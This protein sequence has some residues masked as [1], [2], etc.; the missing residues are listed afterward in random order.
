M[1]EYDDPVERGVSPEISESEKERRKRKRLVG[2]HRFTHFQEQYLKAVAGSE[3]LMHVIRLL[4]REDSSPEGEPH[5][6]AVRKT[7][8]AI[9]T[10]SYEEKARL[11]KLLEDKG[12]EVGA[13]IHLPLAPMPTSLEGRAS[14]DFASSVAPAPVS[15][16]KPEEKYAYFLELEEQ[17]ES[18]DSDYNDRVSTALVDLSEEDLD[19]LSALL[20]E[21]KKV[22]CAIKFMG[23]LYRPQGE[24]DRVVLYGVFREHLVSFLDPRA[25]SSNLA[26]RMIEFGVMSS[27][28]EDFAPNVKQ[29]IARSTLLNL[30]EAYRNRKRIHE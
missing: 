7:D 30:E 2:N 25:D 29:G 21:K 27:K 22:D 9:N 12:D 5:L 3:R 20:L 4:D 16:S 24:E 26:E 6:Q 10:L 17:G 15:T 19:G 11:K 1:S 13:R 18:E 28:L 8:E 23:A 14:E